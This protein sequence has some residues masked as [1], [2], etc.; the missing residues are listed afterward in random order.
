MGIV[1][2]LALLAALAVPQGA[3]ARVPPAD[4][5]L[6]GRAR[7]L[8]PKRPLVEYVAIRGSTIYGVGPRDDARRLVGPST[9]TVE[10]PAGAC[11]LPG[12][13]ESHAHLLSLGHSL[14]QLDLV[15]TRSFEEV[16]AAASARAKQLPAG[17]WLRGRGWDQ[18]DWAQKSFPDHRALSAA[19]PDRPVV[20]ERVDGHAILVNAAAMRLAGLDARTASLPGG[21][22]VKDARGEPTGVLVDAAAAIVEKVVPAPGAAEE[23]EALDLALARC[24]ELGVT[25][26]HDAGAGRSALDLYQRAAAEGRLTARLY[27]ML[28]GADAE[29]VKE[30]LARGP[31]ADPT[32]FLWVRSVKKYADGALGSRGA[33][34]AADYADAPGQRGNALADLESLA[35]LSRRALAAGFQVCTHAIGDAANRMVLDAYEKSLSSDPEKAKDARFR[36]EHAQLLSPEDVAR[37]GKLGV[38]ASMQTCH[39]TSDGPWVP[40]RIGME[41]ARDEA[42]V[43]RTLLEAGA[44]LCNGTDAPVESLSPL[45]NLYSAVTRLDPGGGLVAPFFPE[46]CLTAEEALRAATVSGAY[47]GFLEKKVGALKPGLLADLVVVSLDPVE[48]PPRALLDAVVLQVLVGGKVVFAR[49]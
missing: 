18:N 20:L 40:A 15:G 1:A 16:V 30:W 23:S 11:I 25:T 24:R 26:F 4:L 38:I 46:Q 7:T 49:P 45:R 13:V 39:A 2:S 3:N 10:L 14:R 28:D 8:D 43:W 19:I 29:L 32:G 9:R 42:Y 34:L 37:F 12:F 36:V 35:D 22:I 27:V 44:T 41:R 6:Y 47:A 33:L 17:A 48:A 21:E 5:V 31:L